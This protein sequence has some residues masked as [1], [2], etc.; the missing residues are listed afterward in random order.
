MANTA[1]RIVN[2]QQTQVNEYPWQVGL[3]STGRQ[4]PFC[5]GS[6]ISPLHILTAAHCTEGKTTST[7]R[8]LLGEHDTTDSDAD[9]RTISAITDHPDYI[10]GVENLWANDFS[11]LTLSSP[12]TYSRTMAPVCLPSDDSQ[13]YTG[14]LATVIGW[15]L[16]SLGNTWGVFNHGGNLSPTLLETEVRVTSNADCTNLYQKTMQE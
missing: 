1:T 15:G 12:I 2:G 5:G 8:V 6:I 16:T 14:Q 4:T 10:G 11:I 9:I 7:M 3:V 13:L